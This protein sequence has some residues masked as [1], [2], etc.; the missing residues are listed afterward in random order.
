[1]I[2]LY[3]SHNEYILAN[4]KKKMYMY[5]CLLLFSQGKFFFPRY[6]RQVKDNTNYKKILCIIIK[7]ND[8]NKQN[9]NG[10]YIPKGG[11]D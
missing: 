3:I 1:M 4:P 8:R 9:Q 10:A 6:L 7:I 2:Q 5:F 11:I